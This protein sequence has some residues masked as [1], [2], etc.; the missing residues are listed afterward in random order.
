MKSSFCHMC[1]SMYTCATKD[2]MHLWNKIIHFILIANNNIIYK[3]IYSNLLNIIYVWNYLLLFLQL[4]D[5]TYTKQYLCMHGCIFIP[6]AVNKL[7]MLYYSDY[8]SLERKM[9]HGWSL[10]QITSHHSS[11]W[12]NNSVLLYTS[13]C[14]IHMFSI[15][16]LYLLDDRKNFQF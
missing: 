14:L 11:L 4:S 10:T 13:P 16:N 8:P 5:T 7:V 9:F 2:C 12:E 3:Y 15:Q 6:C 1:I